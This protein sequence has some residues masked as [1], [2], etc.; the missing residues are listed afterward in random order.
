ML[1]FHKKSWKP[2]DYLCYECLYKAP[3]VA[4]HIFGFPLNKVSFD[5]SEMWQEIWQ[6]FGRLSWPKF[7]QS[8]ILSV[9]TMKQIVPWLPIWLLGPFLWV[10]WWVK[11]QPQWVVHFENKPFSLVARCHTLGE[12]HLTAV[13]VYCTSSHLLGVHTVKCVVTNTIGTCKYCDDIVGGWV[14]CRSGGGWVGSGV[15]Y[16]TQVGGWSSSACVCACVCVFALFEYVSF[17]HTWALTWNGAVW[18]KCPKETDVMR[19]L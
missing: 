15:C 16:V 5:V 9:Y 6:D 10:G 2:R 7:I 1:L 4:F 8:S 13:C 3:V 11:A 14:E 12:V 17:P 19:A 18:V